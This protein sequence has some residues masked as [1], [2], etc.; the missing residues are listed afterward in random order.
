MA[1]PVA[2]RYACDKT[3]TIMGDAMLDRYVYGNVCCISPESPVMIVHAVANN[4][5]NKSQ[6]QFEPS[7]SCNAALK[8]GPIEIDI[9]KF[10]VKT[11]KMCWCC[12]V[13][14]LGTWGEFGYE[15]SN[16]RSR[17]DVD[18]KSQVS[19]YCVAVGTVDGKYDNV[20]YGPPI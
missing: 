3:A 4:N 15:N 1:L 16:F 13:T 6:E 9:P 20:P 2:A 19:S 17:I 8:C 12:D 18:C 10:R 5:V 14:P 11:W 7:L